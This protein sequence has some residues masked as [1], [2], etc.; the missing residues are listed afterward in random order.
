MHR[1]MAAIVSAAFLAFPSSA[2]ALQEEKI[3]IPS[4]T[5]DDNSILQGRDGKPVTLPATLVLPDG[6]GLFPAVILLHGSDGPTSGSTWNWSQYLTSL[7]FATLRIDSYTSRGFQEIYTDQGR[8]A[9]FMNVIDTYRALDVLAQDR[10][11]DK[12]RIAVMGF[13]RGGIGALYSALARFE[14]QYG[15]KTAKLAA[16]LPFYPP[17]NFLLDRDTETTGAP[18]RAFHGDAD[19]WNPA[20]RCESYIERLQKAGH[21]AAVTIY[22]GARHSFDSSSSPAYTVVDNAQTSRNCLRQ[23]NNKTLVNASTDQPF[24]WRDA[25]VEM[26]PSVHF[27]GP[28]TDAAKEAV[29]AFLASMFREN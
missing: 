22:P 11:I 2:G 5:L 10:R 7:G 28:A 25:C 12:N 18:I 9:E 26:G 21:D 17:C 19:D 24:S 15:S 14:E 4:V 20:P 29:R 1:I 23:E 13:S 27:N 16:H 6:E 3:G 8:V